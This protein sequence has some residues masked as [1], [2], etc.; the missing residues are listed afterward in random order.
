MESHR[1]DP[2]RPPSSTPLTIAVDDPRRVDVGRLL[3][4]HLAFNHAVTPPGHVHAMGLE[5]LLDPSVTLFSA[6]RQGLLVGVG[7][8]HR[9]G[10]SHGELKSMHTD[11]EFRGNGVGRAMVTHIL[12]FALE[13]GLAR[14]SLETGTMPA[15]SPARHL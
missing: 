11:A 13:L 5:E 2:P 3:E 7:A 8:L 4:R 10:G 6:R 1:G 12:G 14:V 15:F 9:L